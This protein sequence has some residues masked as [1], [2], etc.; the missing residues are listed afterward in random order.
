[1]NKKEIIMRHLK[2][3]RDVPYIAKQA[4]CERNY[5]YVVAKE[6]GV[7]LPSRRQKLYAKH[8]SADKSL[9]EVAREVGVS[10][11]SARSYA[12]YHNVP[13]RKPEVLSDYVIEYVNNMTFLTINQLRK[14]I[15]KIGRAHV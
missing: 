13:Y 5:V 8:F 12:R 3:T 2:T 4:N 14:V 10:Y 1:M 6:M 7:K 11:Q 15:D 9:A